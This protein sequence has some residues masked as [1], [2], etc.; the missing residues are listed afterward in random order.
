MRCVP[1]LLLAAMVGCTT[2]PEIL[3]GY[4][5]QLE[6]EREIVS[7]YLQLLAALPETPE[8]GELERVVLDHHRRFVRLSYPVGRYLELPGTEAHWERF[9]ESI[10]P[11]AEAAHD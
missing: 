8:I 5:A 2:P 7:T 9:F 11:L 3:E 6:I 1:V 10:R 4:E